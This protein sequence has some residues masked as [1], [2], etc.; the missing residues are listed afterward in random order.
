MNRNVLTTDISSVRMLENWVT[1]Q[2][3]LCIVHKVRAVLMP[4]MPVACFTFCSPCA[5]AEEHTSHRKANAAVTKKSCESQRQKWKTFLLPS[6]VFQ[7]STH[8]SWLYRSHRRQNSYSQTLGQSQSPGIRACSLRKP[9]ELACNRGTPGRPRPQ[10]T[11]Q[12]TKN[13]PSDVFQTQCGYTEWCCLPPTALGLTWVQNRV[14]A[15]ASYHSVGIRV[16]I[17][18]GWRDTGPDSSIFLKSYIQISIYLYI[19]IYTHSWAGCGFHICLI[20]HPAP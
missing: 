8:M 4:S 3:T 14:E 10:R 5:H 20:S 17:K 11:P 6:L 13:R 15:S 9:T 18:E 7:V 1:S 12:R 19:K 2:V 16:V